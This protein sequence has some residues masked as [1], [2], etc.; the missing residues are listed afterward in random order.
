MTGQW[1]GFWYIG[2][3]RGVRHLVVGENPWPVLACGLDKKRFEMKP[4]EEGEACQACVHA[5]MTLEKEPA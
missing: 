2:T 5:Q 1:A 4:D 3:R